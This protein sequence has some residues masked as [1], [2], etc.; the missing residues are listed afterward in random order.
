MGGGIGAL[1]V[2]V[3][4]QLAASSGRK[5][6]QTMA[7]TVHAQGWVVVLAALV[8]AYCW[9]SLL[10]RPPQEHPGC[11]LEG[12]FVVFPAVFMSAFLFGGAP[13]WLLNLARSPGRAEDEY[14]S[15]SEWRPV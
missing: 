11:G 8:T 2:T 5:D 15:D 1:L 9:Y 4:G 13:V 6:D 3:A 12:F 10:H 7:E 14:E